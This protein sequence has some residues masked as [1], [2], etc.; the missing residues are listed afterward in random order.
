MSG[1]RILGQ[2]ELDRRDRFVVAAGLGVG[3]GV[4]VVPQWATNALWVSTSL[5]VS[6]LCLRWRLRDSKR[7]IV[8]STV[9]S[10]STNVPCLGVLF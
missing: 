2:K 10:D 8:A 1:V 4:A 9:V 6:C 7:M 3:I 5:V